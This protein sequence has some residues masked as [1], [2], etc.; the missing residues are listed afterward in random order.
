MEKNQKIWNKFTP[1]A[2]DNFIEIELFQFFFFLLI[3]SGLPHTQG[4]QGNSG[5]FGFIQDNGHTF[6]KNIYR[7][8]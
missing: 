6:K 7:N 5:N 4:I 1:L 3:Y 8:F 2:I